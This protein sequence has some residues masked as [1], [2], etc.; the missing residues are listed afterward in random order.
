MKLGAIEL[1][2]TKM[3]LAIADEQLN[4]KKRQSLP[5]LTPEETVPKMLAFFAG[6]GISALGMGSFGPVDL[7]KQSPTYGYITST[8]KLPWRMFP[9][10]GSMQDAL[11]VPCTL[12]TDVNAAAL[13]EARL[14]AAK[15][16]DSCL[17]VTVG[18]G[19]G[20]GLI[21]ENQL[22]HGLIHPEWGHIPL[23]ARADDPLPGG[24]C[25]YHGA[26][27]EGLASGPAIEIRWGVSAKELLPGHPAWD[28]EAHYLA[29]LCVTALMT[30]SVK[31]IILGGGVMAQAHLFPLI[32]QKVQTMLGGY[33]CSPTIDAI[34]TLIVPP[35]CYPDSGLMGSLLLAKELLT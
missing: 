18:T 22:V 20:G 28:L 2:G 5:T 29:Q 30:V 17:Y 31:R 3:V 6:E 27:L 9:L 21:C 15:G 24:I 11:Q 14:G 12:D 32:R 25:P 7:S 35:A 23:A 19:V 16:L 13:C 8:P 26:C 4:I 34:D 10:V 1:G 33:L